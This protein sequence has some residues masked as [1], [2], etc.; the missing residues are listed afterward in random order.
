MAQVTL[1]LIQELRNITGAG[2]MDCK[3]ALIEA[4][5]DIEEAKI[6]LRKKGAVIAEKRSGNATNQGLIHAYIHPGARLG[7]LLEI[8]CETDFVA[9]TDDMKQFAQDLCMHIAAL[10]PKFVRPEE[11]DAETLEKEKA[12]QRDQLIAQ[13][14]PANMVDKILEGKMSKLYE[15]ICLLNQKFVKNDK[16]TVAQILQD[17]IGRLGEK[18]YINRFVRF[19]VES[20]EPK[21]C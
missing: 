11:V 17:L 8:D 10:H 13:G 3:K 16:L 12:F 7:V 9:R 6:I 18:I 15:E 21:Q 19:E 1:E 2:M 5:G 14:K 20:G 4:N